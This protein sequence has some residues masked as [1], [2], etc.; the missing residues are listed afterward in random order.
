MGCQCAFN[1]ASDEG[2]PYAAEKEK[3]G[4]V[5]L[6][7]AL[8]SRTAQGNPSLHVILPGIGWKFSDGKYIGRGGF[9]R[10]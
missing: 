3:Y 9:R 8:F 5:Q 4:Q 10:F 7:D 6:A 2:D 1:M